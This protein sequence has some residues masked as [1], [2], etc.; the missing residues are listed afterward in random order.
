MYGQQSQRDPDTPLLLSLKQASR[1]LSLSE[2]TVWAMVQTG[3]L[4]H[5]RIGRRLLFSTAALEAWI[6]RRQTNSVISDRVVG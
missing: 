6:E 2:R 3:D 4:P 1:A 5:V